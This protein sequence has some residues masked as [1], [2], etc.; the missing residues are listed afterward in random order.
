MRVIAT[1]TEIN[2][3]LS[4]L[5]RDC[6]SCQ[7]AVAWASIGFG[8]FDLLVK[9]AKKID[10]MVVGTHFY[11]TH[12]QFIEKFRTHPNVRFVTQTT[13][14]FHPK[15][16][17]FENTGLKWECLVGSPNFTSSAVSRNDEMAV[18]LTCEDQGAT[19]AVN[20]VRSSI[21]AYW[22]KAVVLDA[23]ELQAYTEAWGQKQPVLKDVQSEFV[24]PVVDKPIPLCTWP[25]YFAV[26]KQ[27]SRETPD[28]H[29]LQERLRVIQAVQDLFADHP[30]FSDM[31]RIQRN[32]VAGTLHH[33]HGI[34][35]GI[36]YHWFGSMWGARQFKTVIKDHH[37]N[38]SLAL[39][40]IPATG[41]VT[42]QDYLE[43]VSRF[44]KAFPNG[45]DGV[46]TATRLLAMKRPD[47]FVCLDSKNRRRLFKDFGIRGGVDYSGY[48]D[49]II[50]KVMGSPWWNAPTP[51]PGLEQ[52]VWKART[53]FL[54]CVYYDGTD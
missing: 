27:R 36:N 13:G 34:I 38:V 25:E 40:T 20:A 28:H 12:P 52:E 21:G 6:S 17:F 46:G 22:K 16:Y 33:A 1:A 15:V 2:Q 37:E 29:D 48:W 8:A 19:A 10:R 54:D 14:V 5:I 39:D 35:D 53:A 11:Q 23:D 44:R 50:K 3:E 51:Q 24:A 7:V 45:G 47:V 4:R 49:S 42:K 31:D 41:E 32:K 43:F 26:L 18:L 9:H 30:R